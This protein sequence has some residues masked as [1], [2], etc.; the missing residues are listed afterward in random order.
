M[1]KCILN[2]YGEQFDIS[3]DITTLDTLPEMSKFNLTV[4]KVVD[5][6]KN[7]AQRRMAI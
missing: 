3:N 5:T 2:Y 7:Y 6:K 4:E 1:V